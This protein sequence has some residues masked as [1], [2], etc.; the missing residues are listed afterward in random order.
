MVTQREQEYERK[1]KEKHP[2]YWREWAYNNIE[3]SREYK[4][5]WNIKNKE[6]HGIANKNYA[7][8]HP[9][10]IRARNLANKRL[11]H[12]KKEGY[13]FHHKDYSK[14]LEILILPIKQHQDI[15]A[16]RLKLWTNN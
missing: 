10:R 11:K 5:R 15:T 16:G 9:D 8:S 13:E 3:K 7:L 1:W 4:R 2:N 6:K 14:P 12:L